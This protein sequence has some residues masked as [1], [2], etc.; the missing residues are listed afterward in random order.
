MGEQRW[1]AD[2]CE[3]INFISRSK[4]EVSNGATMH[5]FMVD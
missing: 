2:T 5:Y 4:T 3:T 1:K